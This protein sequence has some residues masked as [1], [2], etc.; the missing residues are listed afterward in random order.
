[1]KRLNLRN[2]LL[3]GVVLATVATLATAPPSAEA[4]PKA[5]KKAVATNPKTSPGAAIRN[6]TC[7]GQDTRGKRTNHTVTGTVDSNLTV[8]NVT[9]TKNFAEVDGAMVNQP[10]VMVNIAA[11][12]RLVQRDR[13]YRYVSYEL[14]VLPPITPADVDKFSWVYE[15]RVPD[16]FP[17]EAVWKGILHYERRKGCGSQRSAVDRDRSGHDCCGVFVHVLNPFSRCVDRCGVRGTSF[18]VFRLLQCSWLFA[19]A[20]PKDG[21]ESTDDGHDGQYRAE[22]DGE[23][24][25]LLAKETQPADHE[26]QPGNKGQHVELSPVFLINRASVLFISRVNVVLLRAQA[27]V[28]IRVGFHATNP[29]GAARHEVLPEELRRVTAFMMARGW[30]AR[31]RCWLHR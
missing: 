1:M 11:P 29:V 22:V 28:A 14:N 16:V 21:G 31:R 23:P 26:Y 6:F 13:L 12:K 25:V 27:S 3:A 20:A 17:T 4:K 10:T 7:D 19:F 9:V 18:A 8:T 24:T 30:L 15:F 2:L 5:K